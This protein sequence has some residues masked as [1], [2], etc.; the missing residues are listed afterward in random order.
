MSDYDTPVVLGEDL[1]MGANKIWGPL[2]GVELPS[3]VSIPL[4]EQKVYKM[5]GL[6]TERPPL[7]IQENGAGSRLYVGLGAHSW[8]RPVENLGYDRLTGSPEIRALFYGALTH[9]VKAHGNPGVL[10]VIA[11]LPLEALTGGRADTNA[12]AV[13]RWLRGEHSWTADGE[14]FHISVES[15]KVT[16]QATGALFDYILDE[17][18][19]PGRE[20]AILKRE[21]GVISVGFNTVE[22][23]LLQDKRLVPEMSAGPKLGVRRLLEI[24]DPDQYYSLGEL[25]R[26]LR[27]GSLDISAAL[28]VWEHEVRTFVERTWGRRW[29]RFARIILVG[30]GS[31]L[32]HDY[33]L[34]AFNG[35][36]VIPDNPVMSISR[37]LYKLALLQANAR[38]KRKG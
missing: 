25:D 36:A 6:R 5:T 10:S 13:R 34:D 12:K 32:L 4:R 16:S 21:V 24:V 29:K 30:G 33:L 9:Y 23:M 19:R 15:V 27:A 26:M 8:G 17:E 28:P 18:G 31:V 37:G 38:R 20:A 1:G 2:G 11:G 7:A 22:I 3:Q 35:R 14:P